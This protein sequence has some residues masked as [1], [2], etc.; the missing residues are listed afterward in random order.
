MCLILGVGAGHRRAG[1]PEASRKCRTAKGQ[2]EVPEPA[3]GYRA[4]P[5]A[6]VDANHEIGGLHD[7]DRFV[8]N[9]QAELPDHVVEDRAGDDIAVCEREGHAPVCLSRANR[10]HGA[11]ELISG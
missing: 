8:A 9:F 7:G 4:W 11:D 3:A 2:A 5:G 1:E 6:L 10:G